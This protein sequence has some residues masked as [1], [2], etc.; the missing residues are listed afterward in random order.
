MQDQRV[1]ELGTV[2]KV[3]VELH[4]H[5]VIREILHKHVAYSTKESGHT[6]LLKA[7]DELVVMDPHKLGHQVYH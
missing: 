4:G 5:N 6:L 7:L 1:A 3:Y 2:V